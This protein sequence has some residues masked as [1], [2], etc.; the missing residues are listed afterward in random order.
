MY[1]QILHKNQAGEMTIKKSE[2]H[3]FWFYN[4]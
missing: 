2:I 3:T 4:E 1:I